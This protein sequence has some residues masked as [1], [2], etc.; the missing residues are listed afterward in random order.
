MEKIFRKFFFLKK[1]QIKLDKIF[2]K[3]KIFKNEIFFDKNVLN[4]YLIASHYL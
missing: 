3:N 1:N 2:E 4:V